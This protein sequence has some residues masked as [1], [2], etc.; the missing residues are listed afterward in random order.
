MTSLK[1]LPYHFSR[2][3]HL[4]SDDCQYKH[5]LS[6]LWGRGQRFAPDEHGF[7]RQIPPDDERYARLPIHP[8]GVSRRSAYRHLSIGL[9]MHQAYD[10]VLRWAKDHAGEMPDWDSTLEAGLKV[11]HEWASRGWEAEGMGEAAWRDMTEDYRLQS[12]ALI[13][14]VY[15]RLA[16]AILSQYEVVLVEE[17]EAVDLG[18]GFIFHG[19]ADA[20]LR[21]KV[22][23]F[24]DMTPVQGLIV[25][26]A[27]SVWA[28]TSQTLWE[29]SIDAQGFT[30]PW[31]LENWLGRKYPGLAHEPV[32]GIQFSMAIKGRTVRHKEHGYKYNVSPLT[33]PWTG[34]APP[35]R[36]RRSRA[37]ASPDTDLILDQPT[38]HSTEEASASSTDWHPSYRYTKPDGQSVN[39]GTRYKQVRASEFPG[40]QVAWLNHLDAT[41]PAIIDGKMLGIGEVVGGYWRCPPVVVR[42]PLQREIYVQQMA[43]HQRMIHARMIARTEGAMGSEADS[44]LTRPLDRVAQTYFFPKTLQPEKACNKWNTKCAFSSCV[45]HRGDGQEPLYGILSLQHPDGSQMFEPRDPH[46]PETMGEEP[47]EGGAE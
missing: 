44:T 24:L 25:H 3:S 7:W 26:S 45:C 2:S 34:A 15:H 21:P 43:A 37:G 19:R 47:E 6:Y 10:H 29:Y 14:L 28:L 17:D 46:H 30:E 32:S 16:P 38:D 39:L 42:H 36:P 20:V 22:N 12:V 4:C 9:A 5:Y 35:A 1:D 41:N 40:G 23:D 18:D 33:H 11:Y 31:I 27:K 13:W 8:G